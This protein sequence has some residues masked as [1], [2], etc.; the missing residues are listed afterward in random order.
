MPF[1]VP[2]TPSNSADFEKLLALHAEATPEADL[3]AV[4][5]LYRDRPEMDD[6]CHLM[7]HDQEDLVAT[8]SLLPHRHYFGSSEVEVGE[9][10]LVAT[11]PARRLEGFSKALVTHA[12]NEALQ[13]HYA[14]VYLYGIPRFFEPFGFTYAGPA[15]FFPCLRMS[16]E[17]LGSVLSPYRVRPLMAAD[18]PML[19]ELYDQANCR[20]PLAEVRSPA[21]WRYRLSH[22]HQGGFSWWVAVD[23]QNQPH[24]YVWADVKT[25]RLREV[26]AADDEAVRA[27]LQWMRWELT[28]RKLNEFTAQVPLDQV[29]ARHAHRLGALTANP[30]RLYPGNWGAMIK[31]L[32]LMPVLEALGPRLEERIRLSRYGPHDLQVTLMLNEEAVSLRWLRDRLQVAPGSVGREIALSGA[33]WGPLLTGYR[34][35]EDLGALHLQAGEAELL[36]VLFPEGAPYLWDLDHS[37]APYGQTARLFS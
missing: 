31:I 25:A 6:A 29:F 10:A 32:K 16:L 18:L 1:L 9:L 21:Y 2:S 14:Y 20:T 28:E 17:V 26:V 8:A 24:G 35:I 11:R 33:H 36:K 12:L 13:R 27:I 19:E 34:S 30:H 37:D 4:S 22:T 23:E 15:H 3:A 5:R 7:A